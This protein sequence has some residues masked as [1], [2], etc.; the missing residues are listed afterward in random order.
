MGL[1]SRQLR[2][3]LSM[4]ACLLVA[5]SV[6]AAAEDGPPEAQGYRLGKGLRLGDS[7][8]W[9][10][11][12]ANIEVEDLKRSSWQA[13]I[14]DLSL[15]VGW[16]HGR[17]RFF[18]EFELG[19]AL[20]VGNGRALTT[21]Q[22]YFNL[23]RLYLD[24]RV[25]IASNVR[26]GKFLTPIGRWNQIHAAPLVWTTS[27]PLIVDGPFAMHTTGGMAYG[28]VE[29]LGRQWGYSVYGGGRNQLD[30]KSPDE[31]SDDNYRDPIGFRLFNESPGLYQVGMSYAHYEERNFH[32]GVK[33]LLGVDAFWTRKRYELSGEFIYRLGAGVKN[34][35]FDAQGGN[36]NLWG[37]YVQGVA[38]LLGDVYAIA[39][40]E[41]FQREG[42]EAPG[43]LWLAGLAYRPMP[44][45]VFK[46]EYRFADYSDKNPPAKIFGGFTEGF[47]ASIA[48]LF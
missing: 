17:W 35:E 44:P 12:Y 38:P 31:S 36:G 21:H 34:R 47:A 27:S 42:A 43:H 2:T 39:R 13:Q 5:A 25:G 24:F 23:E 10:G 4:A 37:L 19:D 16:E 26:F 20:N 40:Y 8:V 11:G 18:T 48:V 32:R 3:L 45:L 1:L 46:A 15:F 29:A 7:G 9:L 6:C 33:N 22:G 28:S 30:F 14:N 41:A